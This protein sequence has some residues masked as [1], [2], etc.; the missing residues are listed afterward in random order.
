MSTSNSTLG[1]LA[2]LAGL[3]AGLIAIYQWLKNTECVTE[4]SMLYGGSVCV[5]LGLNPTSQTPGSLPNTGGGIAPAGT[6]CTAANT[7]SAVDQGGPSGFPGT[8]NDSG[9]CVRNITP[10]APASTVPASSINT[11]TRSVTSIMSPGSIPL[12]ETPSPL[13]VRQFAAQRIV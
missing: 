9:N 11:P 6:P 13:A 2:A 10:S 8:M 3:G 12:S 5:W 7:Q 4:G 1:Y